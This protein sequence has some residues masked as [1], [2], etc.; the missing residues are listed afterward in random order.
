MPEEEPFVPVTGL[1]GDVPE[2]I[3]LGEELDLTSVRADPENATHKAIVWTIPNP[4]SSLGVSPEAA[5][6][7]KFTPANPGTMRIQATISQG[8]AEDQDFTKEYTIQVQEEPSPGQDFV[9]VTGIT[10]ALPENVITGEEI[11]L[12]PLVTVEPP[13]ATNKAI[14][15]S[16]ENPGSFGIS[17]EAAA[18]GT[19]IPTEPGTMTIR[20]TISQGAAE[21]Q[22][23]TKEY[24]IQVV[25]QD[26][27]VGVTELQGALPESLTLGTA[28]DL[29][30]YIT[31]KPDNATNKTIVWSIE[32]PGSFGISAE[33]A[34]AGKFTPTAGGDGIM[35]IRGVIVKGA[36]TTDFIQD[37]TLAV[38]DP[39]EPVVVQGVQVSGETGLMAK[40]DTRQFTAQVTGTGKVP[41]TLTWTVEGGAAGGGTQIS[42]KGLLRIGTNETS[43]TLTVKAASTANPEVSGTAEVKVQGW[44]PLTIELFLTTHYTR[45]IKGLA[46]AN[47]IWV[48]AGDSLID[49]YPSPPHETWTDMAWSTDGVSWK[50]A[51]TSP[52]RAARDSFCY[53]TY[54]GPEGNKL[55]L[56]G[57]Q[58]GSIARSRDGKSWTKA[59][60]I[61]NN[62]W[63]ARGNSGTSYVRSIAYGTVQVD[64]VS[65]G[66]YVA[67][68]SNGNVAWS[69]DAATWNPI[70]LIITGTMM[71]SYGTGW[72]EGVS[73][74]LFI[75]ET[76]NEGYLAYSTD[77]AT[78]VPV[79]DEEE[80]AALSFTPENK[81]Q[82]SWTSKTESADIRVNPWNSSLSSFVDAQF[83]ARGGPEGKEIFIAVGQGNQAAYAHAE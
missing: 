67:G 66:M 18:A 25:K 19:Y 59:A 79:K 5:A 83:I 58:M 14:V 78:W 2:S 46:Y 35:E 52:L 39:N 9:P 8:A 53:I 11:D 64:G 22:D 29:N 26:S 41:Q 71:V 23:F 38:E 57:T 33:N 15:W 75:V 73:T 47:G 43:I 77:A 48:M 56:I 17:A 44:V 65:K 37:Y 42:S 24:T 6:T 61:F 50:A 72:V 10:G 20:A 28:I 69:T 27:F 49:P 16:I 60:N 63:I 74:S 21:N 32:N 13:N 55:F 70:E 31:V 7:G 54:D 3:A 68:D 81:P 4:E 36:G 45:G 40:K 51:G 62:P 80:Q 12:N 82:T 34:A 1:L 30:A 76:V